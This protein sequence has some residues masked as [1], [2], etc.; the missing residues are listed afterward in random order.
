MSTFNNYPPRKSML[1]ASNLIED[2]KCH[3][4]LSSAE[5]AVN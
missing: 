5:I 3:T 1:K 4:S 2:F